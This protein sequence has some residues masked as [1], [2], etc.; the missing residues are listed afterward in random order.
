VTASSF[1]ASVKIWEA[2]NGRL[3]ASFAA[4]SDARLA[5]NRFA[6]WSPDGRRIL[7]GAGSAVRVLDAET[8]RA[9]ASLVGHNGPAWSAVFSPDGRWIATASADHTA[10]LWRAGDGAPARSFVGH[11][12]DVNSVAFGSGGA[13]LITA[14][15]D[16]TARVWD[17]ATGAPLATLRGHRLALQ[18]ASFAPDER[19]AITAGEDGAAKIWDVASGR[20][21]LSLD[22]PQTALYCASFSADSD[23]VV[24]GAME[25]ARIWDAHDGRLLHSI[26]VPQLRWAAFSP[27]GARLVITSDDGAARVWSV[28]L[29]RR[30]PEQ[31]SAFVR[32][33][34]PL[35][36]EKGRPVSIAVDPSA[37]AVGDAG[38]RSVA[39]HAR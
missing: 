25:G 18:T 19:R 37:C 16:R 31:V 22:E 34:V 39:N 14:S 8:G 7:V 26:A 5:R 10:R 21:L 1:D 23:R 27:E 12:Q 6:N 11:D 30:G 4:P 29:D 33:R 3:V 28:A 24:T 9:V 17:T 20:V 13:R 35:R 2:G 36:L 15:D 38:S 32:C